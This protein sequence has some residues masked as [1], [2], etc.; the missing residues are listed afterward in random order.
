MK[1]KTKKR[2]YSLYFRASVT[3]AFA[4]L[5]YIYAGINGIK[6]LHVVGDV[7][8]GFLNKI[9]HE[10]VC[11]NRDAESDIIPQWKLFGSNISASFLLFGIPLIPILSDRNPAQ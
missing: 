7:L 10:S 3:V 1:P 6:S 4:A 11:T 9:L 5:R 2:C 8:G